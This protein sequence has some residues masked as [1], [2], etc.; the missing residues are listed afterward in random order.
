MVEF[1]GRLKLQ[2]VEGSPPTSEL[3]TWKMNPQAPGWNKRLRICVAAPSRTAFP[4]SR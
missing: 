1:A 4:K 2:Q 3:S